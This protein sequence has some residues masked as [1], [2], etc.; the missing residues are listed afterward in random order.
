[1]KIES[2]TVEQDGFIEVVDV[3]KTACSSLDRHDLVVDPFGDSIRD[4]MRTEGDDVIDSFFQTSGYL[5][6]RCHLGTNHSL[7]PII[8]KVP[9]LGFSLLS[10]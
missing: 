2:A 1:M 5:L 7:I 6:H 9:C 4:P 10:P 3:S 8:E